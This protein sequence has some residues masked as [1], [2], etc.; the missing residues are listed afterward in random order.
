VSPE[1]AKANTKCLIR[2]LI[3]TVVTHEKEFMEEPKPRNFSF[4]MLKP[5]VSYRKDLLGLTPK[6]PEVPLHELYEKYPPNRD[7]IF[8]FENRKSQWNEDEQMHSLNMK[9][10]AKLASVKNFILAPP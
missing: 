10:R 3:G 7:K 4:F 2:E 5:G 8:K 1:K 6:E 9:S